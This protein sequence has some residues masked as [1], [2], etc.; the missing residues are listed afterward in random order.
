MQNTVEQL[1]I[2]T[3]QQIIVTNSQGQI[4][5][6]SQ[7]LIFES[8]LKDRQL[9]QRGTNISRKKPENRINDKN[10]LSKQDEL[11]AAIKRKVESG[12]IT[13]EEANSW[14]P[15]RIRRNPITIDLVNKNSAI[16]TNNYASNLKKLISIETIIT[17]K[18]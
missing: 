4:V 8:R 1:G 11:I 9:K 16:L 6:D 18:Q 13:Q 5:A 17:I 10:I 12:Q 14:M 7:N 15:P 3:D 2:L